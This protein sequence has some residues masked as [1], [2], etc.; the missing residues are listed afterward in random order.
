[1]T[2]DKKLIRRAV[3]YVLVVAVAIG[4]VVKAESETNAVSSR[5]TKVESPCLRYGPKSD[6]CKEAF[7]AAVATITHPEACAVERKAGT[8]R[9]IRELAAE[10]DVT[11]KEPCAGARLAQERERS[12]QREATARGQA[13]APVD[14]SSG[15]SQTPTLTAPAGAEHPAHDHGR[16]TPQQHSG[17]TAPTSSPAEDVSGPTSSGTASTQPVQ[18][19]QQGGGG[20]PVASESANNPGLV[21]SVGST[22][23]GVGDVAGDAIGGLTCTV[24]EALRGTCPK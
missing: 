6:Q 20:A 3:P 5:V 22:V 17:I 19:Q 2:I 13:S 23:G 21:E 12:T 11:F 14:S 16:A 15:S 9:A 10:V 8:L 18:E 4:V 24:A 7:E 1:M